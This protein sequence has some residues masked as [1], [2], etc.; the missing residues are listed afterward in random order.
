[1]ESFSI[2]PCRI[3]AILYLLYISFGNI[4]LESFL[5]KRLT[6]P[7]VIKT[8]LISSGKL[9]KVLM[10]SSALGLLIKGQTTALTTRE[11]L[12]KNQRSHRIS[13]MLLSKRSS[14]MDLGRYLMSP[15]SVIFLG[16]LG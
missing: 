12:G 14:L 7:F 15:F 3:W 1:M 10:A 8:S 13:K 9:S 5:G 16:L 4:T 11:I 6:T 2:F